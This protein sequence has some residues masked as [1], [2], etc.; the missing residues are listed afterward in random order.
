MYVYA[1]QVASVR[2]DSLRS[3]GLEPVWFHCPWASPG[4]NTG[5]ACHALL[6]GISPAQG[7]NSCLL[8]LLQWQA[9]SLPLTQP[10][11][12]MS[13][14]VIVNMYIHNSLWL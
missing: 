3:Y 13:V 14:Y 7:W 12:R 5:V 10:R 4:K 6:R 11:K 8:S 9:E 2:S 1:R